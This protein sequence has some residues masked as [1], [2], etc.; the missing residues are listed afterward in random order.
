MEILNVNEKAL[1]D[2]SIIYAEK[3]THQPY[4]STTFNNNDE[5]RIPI[6]HQDVYTLPSKS[7]VCFEGKLVTEANGTPTATGKFVNF[8]IAHLLDEIRY[9]LN[10]V[11]V[12]RVRNVGIT[13]VMKAYASYSQNQCTRLENAGWCP[14]K[15]YIPSLVDA[16]GNFMVYIP[17]EMLMGI[18]E[19]FRK[20]LLN[21]KQ[22]LV[23]IRG[24]S[25][26]NAVINTVPDEKLKV[27]LNKVYWRVPHISV[28]DVNRLKLL[29]YIE[30][31]TQ[32]E[33]CFRSWDLH[34]YPLLPQTK[35]HTWAIKNSTHVETPRHVIVG[36]QTNRKNKLTANMSQFDHCDLRNILLNLNSDRYPYDNLNLDF[37]SNRYAALYE[38]YA[39]FQSSYYQRDNQPVLSPAEFKSIAPLS[40][41]DSSHQNETIKGG[42]VDVR[43]N[44]ENNSDVQANTTGYTLILNDRT[45]K[46]NPLTSDV[47]V[48]S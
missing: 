43:L 20:I 24:N 40:V 33:I 10:G 5:I 23:I 31:N 25:D 12:D 29:K 13:T 30:N 42:S 7:V 39:E 2:N 46:Y 15:E 11:V 1:H 41:I 47:K 6:L 45:V 8:G 28:A 18:F 38:M 37:N 16:N 26:V 14:T 36:F 27:I 32:L 9:E 19:D 3:H 44:L 4:S 34:E 22:E 21:V 48:I 35:R 17:A